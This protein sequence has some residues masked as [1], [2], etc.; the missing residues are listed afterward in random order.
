MDHGSKLHV[1]TVSID[2]P[3]RFHFQ[4]WFVDMKFFSSFL[5]AAAATHAALA[6]SIDDKD[7]GNAIIYNL[8]E[9]KAIQDDADVNRKC[10]KTTQGYLNKLTPGKYTT[11]G[12]FDC[13]RTAD[14]IYGFLDALQKKHPANI[15][16][17]DV[18]KTF[19]GR[20]IVGYKLSNG[21]NAKAIYTQSLQHAREWASA[22]STLYGFAATLDALTTNTESVLDTYDLILVPIVNLDS[23]LKTWA[24]QRFLRVSAHGIDLNRNWPTPYFNADNDGPGSEVYPGP[25]E[26][27][28]PETAGLHTFFQAHADEIDGA[29]D[30]HTNAAAVLYPFGDTTEDPEEPFLGRFQT[31]ANAVQAGMKAVGGSYDVMQRLYPTYGN[32]RDYFFRNY[33]KPGITVEVSGAGFVVPASTIRARGKEIHASMISYARAAR[34]WNQAEDG[35]DGGDDDTERAGV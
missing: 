6:D 26:L 14:Q 16:K 20:T 2:L 23:Y 34:V 19:E 21:K 9:A 12:F 28:E 24:G 35:N 27:S 18:S 30:F 5:L 1:E 32:V 17:F 7:G 15:S 29:I 8:D 11:N 13:F 4:T 25:Y 22:S 31:L 33:T 10:H 3:L